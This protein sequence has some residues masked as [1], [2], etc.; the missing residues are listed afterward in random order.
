[1]SRK[2]ASSQM[3]SQ[4]IELTAAVNEVFVLFTFVLNPRST[5]STNGLRKDE[6]RSFDTVYLPRTATD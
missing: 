6:R 1:M 2:Q 3:I 5:Q 4:Q